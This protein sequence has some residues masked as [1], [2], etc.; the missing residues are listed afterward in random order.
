MNNFKTDRGRQVGDINDYLLNRK[1][2][3]DH[4]VLSIKI[5]RIYKQYRV[6]SP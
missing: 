6:T 3:S 1:L 2:L 5:Q 4:K